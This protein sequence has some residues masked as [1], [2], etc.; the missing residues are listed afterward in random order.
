MAEITV[1]PNNPNLIC[2]LARPSF[3]GRTAFRTIDG[4]KSISIYP[5]PVLENLFSISIDAEVEEGMLMMVY[6][7]TG[8]NV[9]EECL[10]HQQNEIEMPAD[11][12]KGIYFAKLEN[13]GSSTAGRIILE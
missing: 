6:D 10:S 11:I 3:D 13:S 12:V 1:H 9:Y 4:G 5:N 7:T 8:K 2:A